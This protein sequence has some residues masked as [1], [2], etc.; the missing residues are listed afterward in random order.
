MYCIAFASLVVRFLVPFIFSYFIRNINIDV[1]GCARE[2]KHATHTIPTHVAMTDSTALHVELSLD[3]INEINQFCRNA[4]TLYRHHGSALDT[5]QPFDSYKNILNIRAIAIRN[6][7][8]RLGFNMH[9]MPACDLID[10]A[11][12]IYWRDWLNAHRS[13]DEFKAT[14]EQ[15]PMPATTT[16]TTTQQD[17][18]DERFFAAIGQT[19]SSSLPNELYAIPVSAVV[20]PTTAPVDQADID[21]ELRILAKAKFKSRFIERASLNVQPYADSRHA[22]GQLEYDCSTLRA[23]VESQKRIGNIRAED[24]LTARPRRQT[25]EEIEKDADDSESDEEYID[26]DNGV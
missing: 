26:D 15:V 11:N 22:Y 3:E 14:V 25:K 2:R 23:F 17:L 18:D 8:P 12:A 4:S 21:K 19:S 6:A 13:K 20:E 9:G 5:S 24:I 10:A 16:T 7:K 1:Y